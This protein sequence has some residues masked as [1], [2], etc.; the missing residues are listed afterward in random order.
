M[1]ALIRVT[2]PPPTIL[3]LFDTLPD[4]IDLPGPVIV[5]YPREGWGSRPGANYKMVQ[6]VEFV[7][8]EGQARVGSATYSIDP[9]LTVRQTYD[10]VANTIVDAKAFVARFTDEEYVVLIAATATNAVLAKWLDGVRIDRQIDVQGAEISNIRT[11]LGQVGI[12]ASD[13]RADMV[14]ALP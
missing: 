11:V 3:E 8:P 5:P 4:H 2:P 13:I 1:F 12:L 14:F 7:V 10:T 9:G 6:V